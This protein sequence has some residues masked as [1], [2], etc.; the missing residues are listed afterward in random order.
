MESYP[1]FHNEVGV[2]IVR[3]GCREFKCIGDKPPQDHPHVYLNMGD[4][5]EIGC[6]YCSTLFR[7]DPSLG[8]HEARQIVLTVTWTKLKS[9][10]AASLVMLPAGAFEP[11]IIPPMDEVLRRYR[12]PLT[13]HR[14]EHKLN[15]DSAVPRLIHCRGSF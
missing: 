3:I 6:P 15:R 9:S 2:S 13:E 5:S 10:N 12:R 1:K 7:F 14:P 11:E 8:A 4:A